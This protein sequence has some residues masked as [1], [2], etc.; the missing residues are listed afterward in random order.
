MVAKNS[1]TASRRQAVQSTVKRTLTGGTS[2]TGGGLPNPVVD[3]K[4]E[5][6]G[7]VSGITKEDA[8]KAQEQARKDSNKVQST[9]EATY[10]GAGGQQVTGSVEQNKNQANAKAAYDYAISQG[11][12]PEEAKKLVTKA[13]SNTKF[14]FEEVLPGFK[15]WKKESG[16][17]YGFK[18][19]NKTKSFSYDKQTLGGEVVDPN[20]ATEDIREEAKKNALEETSD[21]AGRFADDTREAL[22]FRGGLRDQYSEALNANPENLTPDQMQ[23]L[24]QDR[25]FQMNRYQDTFNDNLKNVFGRLQNRGALNSSL[26]GENLRRGAFQASGDFMS[27]LEASQ[28]KQMQQYK[29]DA[30]SRTAQRQAGINA[31]FGSGGAA[32]INNTYN[33]YLNPTTTGDLTDAQAYEQMM[34]LRESD[35]G[36]DE[37]RADRNLKANT[38][39]YLQPN[40]ADA[41]WLDGA[42][43]GAGAGAALGP[44]GALG[45]AAIGAGASFLK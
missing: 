27:Q 3:T 18:W 1:R 36:I 12:S 5:D 28:G 23:A 43:S 7:M 42:I 14:N 2:K 30:A 21:L 45:G 24:E 6:P 13:Q 15:K 35:I 25:Q 29:N 31:A 41:G 4:Q 16:A 8:Q 34:R 20:K 32:N 22:D 10:T 37:T 9:A 38:T 39:G 40:S 44:W 11:M 26:L 17:D 33:P 19:N